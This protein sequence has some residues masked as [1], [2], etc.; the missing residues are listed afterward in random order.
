MKSRDKSIIGLVALVI[1]AIIGYFVLVQPRHHQARQLQAQIA[2]EQTQLSQAEAEVQSDLRSE[3]Q[4]ETYV[5]QL[6][7][8]T[9]AVPSDDQIPQLI[10]Q[11]QVASTRN[12][13]GFQSVTV[14]ADSSST[15]GTA[16]PSTSAAT[17]S[18]SFPSQTFN[19]SFTG[20]YFSV[21]RLLGT[22][23][24]FV[25]ADDDHFRA[26]GRLLSI[27]T[28]TLSPGTAASATAPS[29]SGSV[30]AAVSA[31]DYDVPTS[32]LSSP[33]AASTSTSTS[34]GSPAAYVTH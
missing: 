7:S 10:N 19:L 18:A 17:P 29:G 13:V 28:L 5:K 12:N 30:T 33:T 34:T 15:T 2:S 27:S 6:K 14:G 22:L 25:S 23:A 20:S 21:A 11:L 26:T 3:D 1:V 8:I 16:T 4:Y 31:S 24:S 32:L 9:T